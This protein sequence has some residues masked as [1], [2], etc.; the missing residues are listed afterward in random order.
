MKL[1]Q[2]IQA[3]Q[4]RS[5]FAYQGLFSPIPNPQKWVF[6]VGCYNSGTTLLHD[7]LSSHPSIGSMPTEGHWCTNQLTLPIAVNAPGRL[8]ASLP[9]KFYLDENRGYHINVNKLKRHWGAHFND[10]TRPVLL[11]KTPT[12]AARTRWLNKHFENAHFIG[13]IRNGY[14]VA[15][16]IHRKAGHSLEATA[17][18]WTK[19]NE[20]MLRDFEALDKKILISYEELTEFPNRVFQ[21]ILEFLDLDNLNNNSDITNKVW[22]IR[23]HVSTIQNMNDQSLSVLTDKEKKVIKSVAGSLLIQLGY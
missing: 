21:D 10:P 3:I 22:H 18:Q 9:D 11:E 4:R 1:Y 15:E 17:A 14:V 6:V 12:N 23:E 19:S 2:V 20:I 5:K 7:L 8:W 16:R 13:I